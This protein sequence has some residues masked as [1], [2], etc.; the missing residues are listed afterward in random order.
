LRLYNKENF[1]DSR[2]EAGT[3]E[4]S[5][6]ISIWANAWAKEKG[7]RSIVWVEHTKA[8]VDARLKW[9]RTYAKLRS[10]RWI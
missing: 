3:T 10:L 2:R 7:A 8:D 9:N 4:L 5:D 6:L 1:I